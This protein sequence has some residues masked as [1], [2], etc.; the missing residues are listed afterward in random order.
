MECLRLLLNYPVQPGIPT[1]LHYSRTQLE[2][3]TKQLDISE[4]DKNSHCFNFRRSKKEDTGALPQPKPTRDRSSP[5]PPPNFDLA[6]MNEHFENLF[7]LRPSERALMDCRPAALD[8]AALDAGG[9][10]EQMITKFL[11]APVSTKSNF[12]E[13]AQKLAR[14]NTPK[15]G[16]RPPRPPPRPRAGFATSAMLTLAERR[17]MEPAESVLN[18]SS[19]SSSP[20]AGQQRSH[21]K[22]MTKAA[23]APTTQASDGLMKGEALTPVDNLLEFENPTTATVDDAHLS[24][25]DTAYNNATDYYPPLSD[26]IN[27]PHTAEVS[28][29]VP[30]I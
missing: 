15:P 22:Q 11:V 10:T 8:A 26:E 14:A 16:D 17:A 27:S 12:L 28:S 1:L 24:N 19:S 3:P 5:P 4:K 25:K 21:M 23:A 20:A 29:W 2:N 13:Q 6:G 9:S 30:E 18:S 7:C